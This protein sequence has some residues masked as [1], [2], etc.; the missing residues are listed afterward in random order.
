MAQI[1]CFS[2]EYDL[3]RKEELRRQLTPLT[4]VERAVLDFTDVT[5]ID[6]SCLVELL[7]ANRMRDEAGLEPLTI[8]IRPDGVVQ[9]VFD[10][11]QLSAALNVVQEFAP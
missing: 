2:G 10:I 4:T 11:T 9:R 7:R 6:S 8:L 3:A 1:E 5:F